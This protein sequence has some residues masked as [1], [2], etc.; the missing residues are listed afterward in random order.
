[1]L[2]ASGRWSSSSKRKTSMMRAA[3]P[4]RHASSIREVDGDGAE[5]SRSQARNDILKF[6][7]ARGYRNAVGTGQRPAIVVIDFSNAFTRGASNFPGG[8]FAAEMAQTRRLLDAAREHRT[9]GFLHHHRLC[10]PGERIGLLGQEGALAQPLQARQRSGRHRHRPRP[11]PRRGSHRQEISLGIFRNRPSGAAS[12]AWASIRSCSRA[13]RPAYACGRPRSI[14]CSAIFTR[15]SQPKRWATSTPH[16]MP[17]I[18]ATS[19]RATPT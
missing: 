1:M 2:S 18:C 9:A 8:D 7:D 5:K 15:W 17:Y 16:C 13:A 4:R 3:K 10:R 12:S 14:R 11:P 6:Y 19:M